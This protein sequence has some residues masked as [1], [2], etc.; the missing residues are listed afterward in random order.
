MHELSITQNILSIAV[1]K[2]TAAQSRKI[3]RINIVLG[4]LSGIV[5][6]S[7]QF[8]FELLQK[9]T[10]AAGAGLFFDRKPTLL[11]CR[12]CGTTYSPNDIDWNCPCCK[13]PNAEVISGRECYIESIEV[14]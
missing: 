7:V 4:E 10:I 1:E 13:E 2:A 9:E 6:E 14:E 12:N 5:D 11:R 3:T 8:Y